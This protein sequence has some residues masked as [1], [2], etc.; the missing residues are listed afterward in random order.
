[1]NFDVVIP[2]SGRPSL[3]PLL[4]ALPALPGRLIVVDDRAPGAEPLHLPRRVELLES[5]GRGPAAARNVGWRASD[6]EWVA[7]LDDDVAPPAGWLEALRHDLTGLPAEVAGSQGQVRVPVPRQR[8]PTDWERNVARLERARWATADMAYRRRALAA[9]GGFDERFPRAYREDAD[10]GLRIADAGWRIACGRRFVVHPAA[11]AGFWT[12]LRLQRGNADD[13]LMRTLHG[14]DWRL[15]AGAPGGALPSHLAVSAAGCAALALGVAG[16]R[17]Q[18]AVRRS[19]V[20]G[21]RWQ[22]RLASGLARPAF[23]GWALGTG[24]FAWRRIAAGPRTPEEVLKM[25][26][27]SVLIPPLASFWHLFGRATLRSRLAKPG[28]RPEPPEAVLLDRDGTLVVDVPYNGEPERVEPMPGARAALDRLRG[29]GVR[30]AVISNQSGIA[31]G[32]ISEEQLHAVERRVE[33][34]LGPLGPWVV[35]PHGPDD[36]CD[37]RKPRPGLV[38]RAAEE[39]GVDPGRCAVVGDVAADIEAARAAGARAVMVPTRHT[40]PAEVAAAPETAPNLEAAVDILLG[41]RR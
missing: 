16:R 28:P 39:L 12:S 26:V 29:A 32:L 30:T 6:A 40:R 15:R 14:P 18:V 19:Q 25:L 9:C 7:F 20:A 21:G 2:T 10:L 5:G 24:A 4:D 27:T 22:G 13:V 17:S 23:G 37:C 8:R 38:L 35:C 33:E 36:D 41:Q 11:P 3:R 34:L 31:R 1:V